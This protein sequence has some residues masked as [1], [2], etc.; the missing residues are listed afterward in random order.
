MQA[1]HV[2]G[3]C[4]SLTSPT[5]PTSTPNTIIR[6]DR[7]K[8]KRLSHQTYEIPV[9][10]MSFKKSA[11]VQT[12]KDLKLTRVA[13]LR[14]LHKIPKKS[15]RIAVTQWG[16]YKQAL[17]RYGICVACEL[18]ARGYKD[19][20]LDKLG[21]LYEAGH[22]AKPDFLKHSSFLESS[23]NYLSYKSALRYAYRLLFW[24]RCTKKC[25]K[26]TSKTI[27]SIIETL[28]GY[29]IEEMQFND[30]ESL[31]HIVAINNDGVIPFNHTLEYGWQTNTFENRIEFPCRS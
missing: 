21:L 25:I 13:I 26:T 29:P 17:V 5:N 16:P 6:S 18:R 27:T 20:S 28:I 7:D 15:S 14:V 8:R 9:P 19:T 4:F 24:A 3:S 11:M 30:F 12:D 10:Y 22:Y 31:K 23:R 2:S 1:Q